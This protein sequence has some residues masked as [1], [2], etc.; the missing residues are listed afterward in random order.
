[1]SVEARH[2]WDVLPN[3]LRRHAGADS[4]NGQATVAIH[5]DKLRC[6]ADRLEKSEKDLWRERDL[7]SRTRDEVQRLRAE[8]MSLTAAK[9]CEGISKYA[10]TF[11]DPKRRLERYEALH[12]PVSPPLMVFGA[13]PPNAEQIAASKTESGSAVLYVPDGAEV[14]QLIDGRWQSVRRDKDGC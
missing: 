3:D 13:A 4:E 5:R 1:M 9:A 2:R 7:H 8:V 10:S 12:A 6:I 14:Y 11:D